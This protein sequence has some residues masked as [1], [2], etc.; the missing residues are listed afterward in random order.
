MR[1]E[2]DRIL[3]SKY[4]PAGVVVDEDLEVL[5]IRGKASPY[6]TLPVGKVSFNLMKLIPDTGLFLEVEKL[7]RQAR[8]SGEPA[9]QERYLTNT[10]EAP[11]GLNAGGG[12]AGLQSESIDP[13]PF[14]TRTEPRRARGRRLRTHPPKAISGTVQI[15]RLKQQLADAKERFLSAIEAHQTSREES[16][17][18][19]EEALSANEELQSLNEELETAKEELQSTNEELVTVNDE[20]QAKNAALAQARDFAMSIVE[21]VRQP[22]LV[23]DTELRIRMANRAFYQTFRVSPAGSRGAGHLFAVARQLGPSRPAGFAGQVSSRAATRFRTS[24]SSRIFQPL[25]AG[26]WCSAAAASII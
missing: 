1:K 19:T 16:Q 20:L 15:S 17:N 11:S 18:T 24:K 7:I 12:A 3:L 9:R 25:G 8:K 13:G 26:A 4:S 10:T 21:T 2:V 23:L 6:L 22:L 14:R 5:E